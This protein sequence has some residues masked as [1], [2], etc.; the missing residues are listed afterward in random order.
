[1]NIIIIKILTLGEFKT[2]KEACWAISNA[3]SCGGS[4]PEIIRH[5]VEKG[6]IKPLCDLLVCGDNKIVQVSLD[7]LENI[8]RVG[9][10]VKAETNNENQIPL[11]VEI[12]EGT[13]LAIPCDILGVDKIHALQ[14]HDNEEIY[15]KAYHLIDMY[16]NNDEEEALGDEEFGGAQAVPD[17]GYAF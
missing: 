12:G 1:M 5:L 16:F 15:K 17:G 6:C 13:I 8:L 10:Q 3:T 9:E 11:L 7:A 2:K 4:Q 14:F